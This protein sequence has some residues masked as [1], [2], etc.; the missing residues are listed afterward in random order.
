VIA[1]NITPELADAMHLKQDIHGVIITQIMDG[2]AAEKSGLQSEDIVT[3]VDGNTIH[4]AAELHNLMGITHPDTKIKLSVLRNGKKTMITA[5]VA[6]PK[7][8]V[9][10]KIIPYLSGLRLQTFSDL[11]PNSKIVRGAMVLD[12]SDTSA[13]ALAGLIPG[14]IIVKANGKDVASVK[15]LIN[16]ADHSPKDLLLKIIRGNN[17]LFMVIQPDQ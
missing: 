9:K 10:Q 11:E 6:N 14:D 15:S 5:K 7:A 17:N 4:S 1:Q 3:A 16:V 8:E 12:V 13:G 2:S